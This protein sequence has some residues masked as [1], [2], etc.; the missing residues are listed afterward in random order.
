[1]PS[2][3]NSHEWTEWCTN[4]PCIHPAKI[5]EET[6]TFAVSFLDTTNSDMIE[7]NEQS[8]MLQY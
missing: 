2:T 6:Q 8:E 4:L 5:L 1:M 3:L 7:L